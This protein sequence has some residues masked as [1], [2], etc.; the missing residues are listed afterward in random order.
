[1]EINQP[2]RIKIAFTPTPIERLEHL[3]SDTGEYEYEIYIKHDD[4][5][6]STLQGNKVRKLEFFLAQSKTEGADTWITCGGL[7]SNHCR[8]VA[9]LAS[10]IGMK[11]YLMLRGSKPQVPQGN[12]LL[13]KLVGAEIEFV[14]ATDYFRIDELMRD[15]ADQLISRGLTPHI[16]PE[17]GSN[18]LGLWGYFECYRE[19][20][21]QLDQ[22]GLSIDYIFTATGSGGT[23]GGLLVGAKFFGD[24]TKIIGINVCCTSDHFVERVY[25][26]CQEFKERYCPGL[27]IR[28]SDLELIDGYVGDG[29]ALSRKEELKM[30]STLA[31]EC[32]LILDPV[33]TGKAFYGMLDLLRKQMIP[34]GSKI[35]F[36]HTG[37]LWGLMPIGERFV[38]SNL[39]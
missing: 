17:G 7:Q 19:I 14:T 1:M 22:K 35:L 13:D 6:G 27:V 20:R 10:M 4:Y 30:I 33:Y 8:A 37:G 34:V 28:R 24:K 23:F 16:I 21:Q 39:I 15:R 29:Y 26:Y 36:M 32:G 11:S 31:R 9:C 3:P 38:D 12:Y 5:T 2:P 25:Q 18:A